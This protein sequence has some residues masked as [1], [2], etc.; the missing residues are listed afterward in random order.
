MHWSNALVLVLLTQLSCAGEMERTDVGRLVDLFVFPDVGRPDG[1]RDATIARDAPAPDVPDLGLAGCNAWSA[2]TCSTLEM[3]TGCNASCTTGSASYAVGCLSSGH[4]VCGVA[5]G[6]CGQFTA[7]DPCD[8][9]RQ[10]V[11][12]GCCAP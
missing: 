5:R 8:A 1:A 10:A 7:T 9:C 11:M 6:P 12:A 3:T 4:C 2:W